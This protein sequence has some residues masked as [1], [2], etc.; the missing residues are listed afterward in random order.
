MPTAMALELQHQQRSALLRRAIYPTRSSFATRRSRFAIQHSV[1][2]DRR[3]P[4]R[5]GVEDSALILHSKQ[6]HSLSRIVERARASL[7][8][9]GHRASNGAAQLDNRARVHRKARV[10]RS[11]SVALASVG[12]VRPSITASAKT[13]LAAAH[14]KN[15]LSSGAALNVAA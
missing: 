3:F 2:L 13:S 11:A 1:P 14:A 15:L 10:M 5:S 4:T 6:R 7:V 8:E 9:P 12:S